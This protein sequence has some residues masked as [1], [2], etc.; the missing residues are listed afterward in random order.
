MN[1]NA[2]NDVKPGPNAC[3]KTGICEVVNFPRANH[4]P[5]IRERLHATTTPQCVVPEISLPRMSWIALNALSNVAE[6]R[7]SFAGDG[8]ERYRWCLVRTQR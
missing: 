6:L 1:A 5:L 2:T 3:F 7:Y 4:T 8:L